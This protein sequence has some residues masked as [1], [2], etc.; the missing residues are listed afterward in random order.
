VRVV[1]DASA[2]VEIALDGPKAASFNDALR[3]SV[4]ALA[5]DLM[6]PELMNAIWKYHQFE[7]LSLLQCEQAIELGVKLIDSW[8]PSRELHREAFRLA[9]IARKPVYDMFYLALASREDAML[10]TMDSGLKKEAARH[11]ILTL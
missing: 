4:E 11:G 5:P 8:A 6:I 2:A 3:A 10:V 9:R 1:V 7:D